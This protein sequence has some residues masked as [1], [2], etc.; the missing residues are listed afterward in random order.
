MVSLLDL[1]EHFLLSLLELKEYLSDPVSHLLELLLLFLLLYLVLMLLESVSVLGKLGA[2]EVRVD[3]VLEGMV[4]EAGVLV[5]DLQTW[6][7]ARLAELAADYSRLYLWVVLDRLGPDHHR[8]S[9]GLGL[10]EAM[11]FAIQ[12][13]GAA[14][15]M[16]LLDPVFLTRAP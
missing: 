3:R 2:L 16:Q 13:H 4:L 14:M 9:R 12:R 8:V 7:E 11:L 15:M 1:V 10:A 6:V 5:V